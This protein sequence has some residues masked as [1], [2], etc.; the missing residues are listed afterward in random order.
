MK[1]RPTQFFIGIG[2][3]LSLAL[4]VLVGIVTYLNTNHGR[5][6]IQA[7]VNEAI[8]G[9]VSCEK[10][11]FSIL[12][13]DLELSRVVLSGPDEENV[14]GFERLFVDLAWTSLLKGN[15]AFHTV[16]LEKPWAKILK[17]RE[18]VINFVRAVTTPK[19][20]EE[21]V[22]AKDAGAPPINV[23]VKTLRVVKGH[24][25]YEIVDSDFK[26]M[27][28]DI[29][30][31]A[32]GNVAK[33]SGEFSLQTGQG[34]VTS[35]DLQ[36]GFDNF[37]LQACLEK[38]TI[39]PLV[40]EAN[41]ASSR[42]VLSGNVHNVLSKPAL[43]LILDL[44]VSLTELGEWFRVEP[45]ST[46]HVL[47]RVA[48]QGVPD[49]PEV[50][51]Q[52]DYGGGIVAGRQIDGI[53][54]RG[55]LKDRFFKLDQLQAHMASGELNLHGEADLRAAFG[56]GFFVRTSDLDAISYK[57]FLEE[58]GVKLGQLLS[59][60]GGFR[61]TVNSQLSIHGTGISPKSLS[62]E[63]V[64]DIFAKGLGTTQAAAPVDLHISTQGRLD[65]GVATIKQLTATAGDNVLFTS[66]HFDLASREVG[67]TL[68]LDAP[69][70]KETLLALGFKETRGFIK[71]QADVSGSILRP[72][73]HCTLRGDRLRFED[74]TVGD[75]RLRASLNESGVLQVLQLSVENQGSAIEGAGSI[76]VFED[77]LALLPA[78]PLKFSLVLRDGEIKDFLD[79]EI[80]AGIIDGSFRLDG[81]TKALK[82]A[83]TLQGKGMGVGKIR[84]GDID[85]DLRLSEGMLYV[86]QAR[87]NNRGSALR[88]WGTAQVM[89]PETIQPLE[90]PTFDLNLQGKAV[91]VEDFADELKGNITLAAR[92]H[93]HM[94]RPKGT[95][96]LHGINLDLGVQKV[97]EIMIHSNLDGEKIGIQPLQIVLAPGEVIHGNG[98]VSLKK[99]FE[100][101]L[102]SEGISL[103][104]I[105]KLQALNFVEG[106]MRFDIA[107][108][109][110][111]AAPRIEGNIAL[112]EL[113]VGGKA[114]DD[115]GLHVAVSDQVAT[116]SGKLDF[117]L[118]G[119]FH[120]EDKTFSA[121]I[122]CYETDLGPYLRI[123]GYP[124]L[125]GV[126]TGKLE[127][128]GNAGAIS[129]IKAIADLSKLTLGLKGQEVIRAENFKVSLDE[130]ELSVP[131]LHLV[132][133]NDGVIDFKGRGK[134]D[135]PLAF[136]VGG[137][138]P[139]RLVSLFVEDLA[140]MSG[141]LVLSGA[142]GGTQF[143]PDLRAEIGLKEVGFTVPGLSQKLHRVNGRLQITPGTVNVD[144]IE[145]QLGSGRFDLAG[146][147]D[148]ERFKPVGAHL[149]FTANALPLQVPDT[150]DLLVNTEL[151]IQGTNEQ[152]TVEGEIII[153]EG[154][155]YRDVNLSLLQAFKESKRE[156]APPP[157]E[158][159][160]PL[161]R[162][163]TLDISI[164]RRNPFIVENNLAELE[165]NPDL[166]VTGKLN[167]PIIR[168]RAAVDS[169]TLYYRKKSFVVKKGVIDFLNPYKTEPTID[170]QSEAK[171]RRWLVFLAVSGT[172]DQ[173][174]F[175][176]TSD[177]PEEHGDI[178][179][180]LVMGKTTRELI[181]G[182]GGTSKSTS[183]MLAEVIASRYSE[184]VKT[185]TGLDI[186]EV[187]AQGE[188]GEETSDVK[189]T[190]GKKLSKRM[191]VKYATESKDG[192]MIEKAIA[193]YKFL[194][195]ILVN[196]FQDST[197]TFGGEL[198][199]RLEFR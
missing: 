176:L 116:I 190:V 183:Q 30:L 94:T 92:L 14:A 51:I 167:K 46:G 144:R 196:G 39:D 41:T 153:L 70:L 12:R 155:Y 113:R 5:N 191:T 45:I 80:A 19:S 54:L 174:S 168:G 199:F 20:K 178:L 42:V 175:K 197:G 76:Q 4:L 150:M 193:E 137:H 192:E 31:S 112:C 64:L 119:S 78:P 195:N 120:L 126:V 162:N 125:A 118:N 6:F 13:G 21:T 1:K 61:G 73:V 171:I 184:D 172:P 158:V 86:D 68:K 66:G 53:A 38:E 140:D 83:L 198:Q 164:K 3:L 88:M 35:P 110:S 188:E 72:V 9:K 134:R 139:L 91:A 22:E 7:K 79:K 58:E 181:D 15:L 177:P 81:S 159:V 185:A 146:R 77:A 44:N 173:L 100:F 117:E 135:G 128:T 102:S 8:P 65:K 186:L 122:L 131:G 130:E 33:R 149:R 133:L 111:L 85:V 169:G 143:R 89:K 129:Q 96:D 163:V 82:G 49:N 105:D 84:L 27:V 115:C 10:L 138:I 114:L 18:G 32:N 166:R 106:K 179:A 75:V 160:H 97:T 59:S 101:A 43:D 109:G 148:L 180:L 11:R 194:E 152:A 87:V 52:L 71:L 157:K 98:W 2:I 145:G 165:I 24:L 62:A 40:F 95:L 154:T 29:N 50:A 132:L 170:I 74:I 136:E 187:Q 90:D 123:A 189:V 103:Q 56:H 57:V 26:A 16:V 37:L 47:A 34:G 104:H 48:A 67:G 156:E 107:G 147:V 17:D 161:I 142:L 108:A 36:W 25:R 69:N 93:G 60:A 124:D 23:V 121:F 28:Q 63:A 55:Q 127:A 151:K 182:E 141:D 99:A